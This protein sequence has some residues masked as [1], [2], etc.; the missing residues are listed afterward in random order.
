M[1]C[2]RDAAL[3][4]VDEMKHDGEQALITERAAFN[5]TIDEV[6]AGWR[7]CQDERDA[8]RKARESLDAWLEEPCDSG[9]EESDKALIA[10]IDALLS[11]SH[12]AP[13]P[14]RSP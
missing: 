10:R 11:I 8:M 7:E 4:R 9:V 14:P 13:S 1:A 2:E 12:T 6:Q 5:A 3:A